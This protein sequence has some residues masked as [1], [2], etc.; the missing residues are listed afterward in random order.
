MTNDLKSYLTLPS[1][2]ISISNLPHFLHR[3]SILF[4]LFILP[5]MPYVT[6]SLTSFQINQFIIFLIVSI[7]VRSKV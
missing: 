6:D 4:L 5:P 7:F 3:I 1:T 2:S